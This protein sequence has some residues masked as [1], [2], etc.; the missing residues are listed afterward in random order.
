MKKAELYE[1]ETLHSFRRSAVQHAAEME[2]Y[3]AE[4]LMKMGRTGQATQ[5]SSYMQKRCNKNSE[6]ARSISHRGPKN[7]KIDV[8]SVQ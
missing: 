8:Q 6:D 7:C 5:R 3:N 4:M 2:G 1:G